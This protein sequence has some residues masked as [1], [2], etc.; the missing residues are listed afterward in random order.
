MERVRLLGLPHQSRIPIL[1]Y[2]EEEIGVYSCRG[3]EEAL[4]P[5]SGANDRIVS[6]VC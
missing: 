5:Y 1:Q 4:L 6:G 2:P 3:V